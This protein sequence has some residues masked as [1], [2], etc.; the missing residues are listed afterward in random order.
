MSEGLGTAAVGLA[1][2]GL[3]RGMGSW[4]KCSGSVRLVAWDGQQQ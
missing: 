1:Q 2:G 3:R 4:P